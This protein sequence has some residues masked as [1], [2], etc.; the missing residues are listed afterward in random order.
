[1]DKIQLMMYNRDMSVEITKCPR[2]G[3]SMRQNNGKSQSGSQTAKCLEC[4]KFWTVTPKQKGYSQE[5]RDTAIKM[6]FAGASGR[7]IG[8]VLGMSKANVYN[9]LKK[10]QGTVDK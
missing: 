9:W 5:M 4:G 2:C 10:N 8:N 1:M 6:H 7:A 3:S